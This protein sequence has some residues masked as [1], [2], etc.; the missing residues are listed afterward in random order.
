MIIDNIIFYYPSRQTGG[1]QYLFKR[2]AEY[3]AE[4]QNKYKIYYIDYPDGFSRRNIK[5]DKVL[6]LDFVED[7]PLRICDGSIII[8]QLNMIGQYSHFLNF[9]KSKSAILFWCLHATNISSNLTIRG[10]IFLVSK[11]KRH[12]IGKILHELSEFG[13]VKFMV[14][15]SCFDI[16]KDLYHDTPVL[17][18]LPNIIDLNEDLEI[19]SFSRLDSSA[20]RFCWLGRLDEEKARNIITYMNELESLCKDIPVELSLI[21]MGP[22]KNMLQEKAKCYSYPIDFVGEKR[23]QDLDLYIRNEVEIGLASGTSALEF[24]SRGKPVIVDWVIDKVFDAGERSKYTL[25]HEDEDINTSIKDKLIRN[26]EATFVIKVNEI[27]SEYEEKSKA[28]YMYAKQKT[29]ASGCNKLVASA[30]AISSLDHK[31]VVPRI[32]KIEQICRTAE[33]RRYVISW[34]YAIFKKVFRVFK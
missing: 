2:S 13:V 22:A 26:Q 31:I 9:D 32:R 3:L 18:W 25:I 10:N 34:G 30:C 6:F 27:L 29:V 20:V 17:E 8:A 1:T 7:T 19:P 16:F 5:T 15:H 14:Y 11:R 28:E 23:E 21:G 4:S 12:Q 24:A 33:R